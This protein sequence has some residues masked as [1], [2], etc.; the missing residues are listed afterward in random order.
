MHARN[1]IVKMMMM[2][3][4]EMD[5]YW[6]ELARVVMKWVTGAEHAKL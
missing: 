5:A 6:R 1:A 3:P 4:L 2:I